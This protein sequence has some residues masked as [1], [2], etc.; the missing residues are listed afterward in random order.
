MAMHA[1]WARC[2][3][4]TLI[5][6][7]TNRQRPSRSRANDAI[8]YKRERSCKLPLGNILTLTR[9][10][11]ITDTGLDQTQKIID[12]CLSEVEEQH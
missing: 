9:S 4:G 5:L 2:W 8:T 6:D 12:E 7:R 3:D 11:V 1:A 10:L